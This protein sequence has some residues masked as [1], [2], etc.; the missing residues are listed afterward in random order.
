VVALRGAYDAAVLFN[1]HA[2]KLWKLFTTYLPRHLTRFAALH[3]ADLDELL[4]ECYLDERLTEDFDAR[5]DH[6]DLRRAGRHGR[7]SGG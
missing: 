2:G 1:L 7:E 3:A 4:V 5:A 6:P